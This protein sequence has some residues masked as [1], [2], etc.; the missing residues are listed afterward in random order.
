MHIHF[1]GI[2]GIGVSALARHFM[3]AKEV[4]TGSDLSESEIIEE[5]KNEGAQITIG[6]S[7]KNVDG[8]IDRIIHTAA[9][10]FD[11]PEIKRGK[12]LG[13]KISS[14]PEAL[15]EIGKDYFT[16]AISGTHGKSTTAAMTAMVLIEAG[17]DP[18][19]VVGTK[20]KEFGSKNYRRGSSKYLI[21]EA[22]EWNKS[23]LNYS[24]DLAVITNLELEH[25]DSYSDLEDL[26]KTFQKYLSGMKN[27]PVILNGEDDNLKKLKVE[28]KVFFSKNSS[29]KEEV[30]EV[31]RVPGKH[32]LENALAAF[33]VGEV[34]EIS[35]EDILEGLAGYR[36]VWRRFEEKE[37]S[38]FGRDIKLIQ[39]Y[40][41]HPTELKATLD[42]LTEKYGKEIVVVF[43]P[44]QYKRSYHLQDKFVEV[45]EKSELRIFVTDIYSVAG[46]ES[47][48]IK[49]KISSKELVKMSD[50]EKV[51]YLPGNFTD[52]KKKL[53][54]YL[55][56]G[57]NIAIIGAGDIYRLEEVLKGQIKS[58]N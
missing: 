4:V 2:G 16:I 43:Q 50:N 17:L 28:N 26:L 47:E 5:L 55:Q 54:C 49:K 25:L 19:V 27:R 51:S 13:I 39:D 37:I 38:I 24:P 32:N 18:T 41:H 34:L 46:R 10:S 23:I 52:I 29:A 14:Y 56:D 58:N 9:V 57:K 21:I 42:A 30:K 11:N 44:H 45:L 33:K 36:G 15:S 8:N 7:K 22:D 12:E 48:E 20:L 3:E 31:L 53:I 35:K 40:A 1:V 6:H